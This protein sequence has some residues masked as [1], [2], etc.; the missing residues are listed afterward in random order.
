M[1]LGD[2]IRARRNDVPAISGKPLGIH[3]SRVAMEKG[4]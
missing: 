3:L 2:A 1:D 4:Q